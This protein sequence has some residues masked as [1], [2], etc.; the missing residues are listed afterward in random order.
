[1]E[2]E[3]KKC[4]ACNLEFPKT[5]DY[6]RKRGEKNNNNFRSQCKK[7]FDEKQRQR[8]I[9]FYKNNTEK[10]KER[11]K[12][13]YYRN[14]E[15]TKEKNRL[16]TI[17]HKQKQ[18]AYDKKRINDLTDSIILNRL[19]S[20]TSLNRNEIPKELIETKRLLT[21]LKRTLKNN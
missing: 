11:H 2:I 13:F 4:T 18:T 14:I 10:E 21:K 17:K 16:S 15:H 5:I 8:H 12:Y 1:M 20:Q 19:V 7:C 6:F 3:L 9:E